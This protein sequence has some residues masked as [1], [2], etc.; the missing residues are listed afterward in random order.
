MD[1]QLVNEDNV[2][3]GSHLLKIFSNFSLSLEGVCIHLGQAYFI[4]ETSSLPEHSQHMLRLRAREAR[5][6]REGSERVADLRHQDR[7]SRASAT[8][9]WACNDAPC[10][11][12][13]RRQP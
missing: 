5:E 6:A 4:S 1:I 10:R 13:Q 12:I 2:G 11:G 9:H 8:H 3:L 7:I